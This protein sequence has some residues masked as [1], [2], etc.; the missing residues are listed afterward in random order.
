[1]QNILNKWHQ[2]GVLQQQFKMT[3]SDKAKSRILMCIYCLAHR[4]TP[5]I[6][7]AGMYNWYAGGLSGLYRDIWL[8]GNKDDVSKECE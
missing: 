8:E 4:S 1:M 2:I 6:F 3:K 7:P 5:L